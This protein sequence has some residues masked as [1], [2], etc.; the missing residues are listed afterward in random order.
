MCD[1]CMSC[2]KAYA[3]EQNIREFRKH[4]FKTKKIQKQKGKCLK[5]NDMWK[6]E[7]NMNKTESVFSVSD[8]SEQKNLVDDQFS[9]IFGFHCLARVQKGAKRLKR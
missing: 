9:E 5:P 2:G 4:L 8:K 1:M 7:M 6:K 3:D